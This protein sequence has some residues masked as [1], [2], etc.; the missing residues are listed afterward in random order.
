MVVAAGGRRGGRRGLD[1]ML[2]SV[3]DDVPGSGHFHGQC[4]SFPTCVDPPFWLVIEQ[5]P[6]VSPDYF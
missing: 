3:S 1:L 2:G 4:L 5:P 6:H